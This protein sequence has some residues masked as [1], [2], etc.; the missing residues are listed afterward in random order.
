VT[1]R[2]GLPVSAGRWSERGA[3]G[4]AE[5]LLFA[6]LVLLGGTLVI[7]NCWALLDTRTALDAAARAYLRTY[8]EQSDPT[9]AS[10][11][12]RSAVTEVLADRGTD[13]ARVRI[14][15]SLPEGFGP[16]ARVGVELVSEVEWIAVPQV[17]GFGTSEVRVSHSELIDA[18]REVTPDDRYDRLTT[19][20]G[21]G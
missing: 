10:V 15:T 13:P 14:E 17:A 4:G 12:G 9:T 3:V 16:C 1:R 21:A 5:G 2:H 20:C 8:T 7:V 6:T 11:A 19:A 18:H